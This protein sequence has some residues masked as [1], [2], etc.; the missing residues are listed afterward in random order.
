M[1]QNRPRLATDGDA[2]KSRNASGP[3]AGAACTPLA[4][5][6]AQQSSSGRTP[7]ASATDASAFDAILN[8]PYAPARDIFPLVKPCRT[9]ERRPRQ[10]QAAEYAP[11][12]ANTTPSTPPFSTRTS[13]EPSPAGSTDI[14]HSA[15]DSDSQ[16]ERS[17]QR[18]CDPLGASAS[19]GIAGPRQV[20]HHFSSGLASSDSA[21][22]S[23][24][25]DPER[26]V[27]THLTYVTSLAST[28]PQRYQA[29]N[30]CEAVPGPSGSLVHNPTPTSRPLRE[31][32][33]RKKLSAL[34]SSSRGK[35]VNDEPRAQGAS[36]SGSAAVPQRCWTRP[37]QLRRLGLTGVDQPRHAGLHL[38]LRLMPLDPSACRSA[39]RP[40]FPTSPPRATCLPISRSRREP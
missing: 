31:L 29:A 15:R 38:R 35:R 21:G 19:P 8:E 24:M 4:A 18:R 7:V 28:H 34:L 9:T 40:Q 20:F 12:S 39:A 16:S 27:I 23:G 17:C 11:L 32:L 37:S 10:Q 26:A 25:V 13:S 36:T 30:L 6:D 2:G 3:I 22:S 1:L 33:S 5:R 14:G